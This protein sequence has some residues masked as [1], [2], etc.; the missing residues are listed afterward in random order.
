LDDEKGRKRQRD[1]FTLEE[2]RWLKAEWSC[3]FLKSFLGTLV[4]DNMDRAI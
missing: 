2:K 4:S 3:G 1:T